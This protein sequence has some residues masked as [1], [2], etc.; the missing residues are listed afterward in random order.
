MSDDTIPA[1]GQSLGDL[2]LNQKLLQNLNGK[3][4]KSI[5]PCAHNA[6][7][8][9]GAGIFSIFWM[10]VTALITYAQPKT[11]TDAQG[12][13]IGTRSPGVAPTIAAGAPSWLFFF[14]LSQI[15]RIPAI[16]APPKVPEAVNHLDWAGVGAFMIITANPLFKDAAA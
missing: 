10:L 16:T 9:A 1:N 11:I 14:L 13:S 2:V 3:K 8:V 5:Y 12:K 6:G 15:F 4:R 7:V